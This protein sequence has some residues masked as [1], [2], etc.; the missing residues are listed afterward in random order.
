[1]TR[2]GIVSHTLA[3]L[4][5]MCAVPAVA[6]AQAGTGQG[7]QG[8]MT[9]E[10][11]RDGFAIAPDV[12]VTR[13][14]G[15]SRALTGLYGGWVFDDTVLVGAG[16]YF[17]PDSSSNRKL[18]YGGAVVEWRQHPTLGPITFGLRGLAGYGQ[19]TMTSTVNLVSYGPPYGPFPFAGPN[20]MPP[21]TTTTTTALVRFD[22]GFFVF[23]PEAE[24]VVS[25][26]RWLR[27]TGSL[28]YRAIGDASGMENRLRGASGGLAL[29]FGG[30][31]YHPQHP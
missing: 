19:A 2:T 12:K 24:L 9:V 4:A 11:A 26:A 21:A 6:G 15:S 18:A 8:P 22:Q 7:G 23:E 3:A 13:L 5:M 17:L 1:M 27:L 16:G 30:T 25:L 14:D 29:E 28:G 10:Q 20:Q 31:S